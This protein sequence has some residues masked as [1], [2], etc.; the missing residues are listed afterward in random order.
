MFQNIKSKILFI[1]CCGGNTVFRKILKFCTNIAKIFFN[2]VQ[3]CYYISQ[4]EI[5]MNILIVDV[6][7]GYIGN[8][9]EYLSKLNKYLQNNKFEN[10]LYTRFVATNNDDCNQ[11]GL[12]D[13]KESKLAV[14]KIPNSK[15]F[16][17]KCHGLTEQ[18][19]KYLK[20]N[21]ITDLQLCGVDNQGSLE[22]FCHELLRNKIKVKPLV[23]LMARSE[24]IE[25]PIVNSNNIMNN[26]ICGFYIAD[27]VVNKV[28]T[29]TT[30]ISLAVIEWL[31]QDDISPQKFLSTI[32]FYYR[33]YPS[34]TK[35]CKEPLRLWFQNGSKNFRQS[36]DFDCLKYVSPIAYFSKD[37]KDIDKFV[38]NC[39]SV[40]YNSNEAKYASQIFCGAIWLLHNGIYKKELISKINEIYNLDFD[41]SVKDLLKL[42]K[43]DKSAIYIVQLIVKIFVNSETMQD[44]VDTIDSLKLEIPTIKMLAITFAEVYYRDLLTINANNFRNIPLKFI[45]IL[46]SCPKRI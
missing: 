12:Q 45:K 44:I 3:I 43:N 2:F 5:I 4:G 31:S 8:N 11:F 7:K 16:I 15:V 34:R 46:A 37:I 10:V 39:L 41:L 29:S 23:E 42:L 32:K 24:L 20:N 17:K 35:D 26:P 27:L 36:T 40:I 6:Q 1:F 25:T 33:L 19:I 30:I 13:K 38:N 14:K 18:M 9:K 21:N 22:L 28:V